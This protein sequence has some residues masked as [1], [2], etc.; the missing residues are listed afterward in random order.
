ML[1]INNKLIKLKKF[2]DGTVAI[3]DILKNNFTKITW[4]YDS[5]EELFQLYCLT[6]YLRENGVKHIELDMPYIPNARMD[7]IISNSSIHTLKYFADFLNDLHFDKVYVFD[8]HSDISVNLINNIV[9]HTPEKYIENVLKLIKT[10]N[11]FFFF[12]DKGAMDRYSE[13]IKKYDIPYLFGIKQ[14]DYDKG[15]VASLTISNDKNIELKDMNVL[16]VDDIFSSGETIKY[17]IDLLKKYNVDKIYVFVSHCE[18]RIIENSLLK[19]KMI[20]KLFTTDSI[21][22]KEISSVVVL[23]K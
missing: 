18:N 12:P 17:S 19:N 7:K 13:I 11:L 8:P 16:I 9:V 3:D 10:D 15:N 5:D 21:F 6:H 20:D 1:Y 22:R 2:S 4:K 14:R 23:N